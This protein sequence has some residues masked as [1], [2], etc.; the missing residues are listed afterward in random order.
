MRWRWMGAH[1]HLDTAREDAAGKLK[2]MG[3]AKAIIA[4]MAHAETI[5]ALMAGLAPR[6]RLVLLGMREETRC[7]YHPVEAYQKMKSGDA[8]FSEWS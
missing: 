3:E 2:A 1:V 4:T 7:L 8:M 5:S 6:G